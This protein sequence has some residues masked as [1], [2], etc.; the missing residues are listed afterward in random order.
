MNYLLYLLNFSP[1]DIYSC[2]KERAP[3]FNA[4]VASKSEARDVIQFARIN[5]LKVPFFKCQDVILVRDE[6]YGNYRHYYVSYSLLDSIKE[7]S[8]IPF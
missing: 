1:Y 8:I 3:N 4:L 5:Q 2:L 6:Q 7:I